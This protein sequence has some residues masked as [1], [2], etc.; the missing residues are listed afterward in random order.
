[1]K[2]TILAFLFMSLTAFG[3]NVS[4]L[5]YSATNVTTSAYVTAVAS[6]PIPASQIVICDNSG[7]ILKMA[8]GTAGNEVDLTSVPYNACFQYQL[9]FV[10]PSG[11]RIS[12]KAI[13][14]SAT[15]GYDTVSLL[16]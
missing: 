9:G 1:M 15:S 7:V 13:S 10:L 2:K 4:S 11:T 8:T 16:P 6:T 12:L 14:A 5:S 3:S